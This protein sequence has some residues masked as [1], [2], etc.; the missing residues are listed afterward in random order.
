[1]S[2]AAMVMLTMKTDSLPFKA[3]NAAPYWAVI[4]GGQTIMNR[5]SKTA[6]AA[7]LLCAIAASGC[8]TKKEE[9]KTSPSPGATAGTTASPSPAG[10]PSKVDAQ[11][12]YKQNC[13]SC[14]GD[15]LEGKMGGNTNLSKVGAKLSKDKIANQISN[16]GGGMMAF[17]GKLKDEEIN[18]L[19]EWLA[20]K[21]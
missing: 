8:A 21:K 11:S 13:V 18:A 9:P 14:H 7:L 17:K 19:A 16:G 10:S 2:I 3:D 20:A 4:Q 6:L 1:M 15:N 12:V 5:M